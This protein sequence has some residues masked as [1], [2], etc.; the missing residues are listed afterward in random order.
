MV[1]FFSN[2]FDAAP[3][4]PHGHC[5][6]WQKDIVWLNVVANAMIA[7]AYFT[8]PVALFVFVKKRKDIPFNWMFVMFAS[9]IFF[10]GTT[11]V[12]KIVTIWTPIYRID[13]LVDFLTGIISV[14]TGIYLIKIM[15]KAL[16]M[17]SRAQLEAVNNEL[18]ILNKELKEVVV[19]KEEA[20]SRVREERD[21]SL[22]IINNSPNIITAIDTDMKY[23]VFN[24][25][26]ERSTGYKK[27]EVIGRHITEVFPFIKDSEVERCYRETLL[28]KTS[29]LDNFKYKITQTSR[30]GYARGTYSPI[31]GMNGEITGGL[32]ILE[33]ITSQ[34]EMQQALKE[35]E[36]RYRLLAEN[37][38][39]IISVRDKKGV[40]KYVS[41]AIERLLHYKINEVIG[42]SVLEFAHP[43]DIHALKELHD[44]ASTSFDNVIATFRLR[45]KEGKYIWF[46]SISHRIFD[47][48]S[49][50]LH[51]I[52]AA[53]RDIT[54]RKVAEDNL[55]KQT[56][57]LN[58]VL[59]NIKDGIVACDAEG[60]LTLFNKATREFHGMS[61]LP[62]LPDQWPEQYNLF[63]ADG[64]TKMKPDDVPLNKAYKGEE[65]QDQEM[66]ICRT[67]GIKF[68]ILASGRPIYDEHNHKIGAVVVMHNITEQKAAEENLIEK[69]KQLEATN[70]ELEQF[71]YVA[72][73]DLKEPLRM[74]ASYSQLLT[75]SCGDANKDAAEYTSYIVE[76][77]TRMQALLNDLL[78]FSTIDKTEVSFTKVDL[79]EVIKTVEDSLHLKIEE[80]GTEI[81]K[82]QLPAIEAVPSQLYLLFQNLIENA[83][84]FRKEKQSPLINISAEKK[85]HGEW[86]FSIKDNGIGMEEKY[87]EKV[88]VIFQRLHTRDKY[89]GTGIGLAL[90]RK[91]VDFHGGR[92]WF[93]SEPGEGTTFFFTLPERQ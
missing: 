20:E 74:I 4:M 89:P 23:T 73:H 19:N 59:E 78:R 22:S 82:S 49:G 35:S 68:H 64:E 42:R 43:D 2:L 46:E 31:F 34:A 92:I 81:R 21:F 39:D 76:G 67:D 9:F 32:G 91:I 79:N 8:I 1:E 18:D 52:H 90:C 80:T 14:T 88:F 87:A 26:A 77:V 53:S 86:L 33:D 16:T 28:G 66:V 30:E 10:C 13:A 60:K 75:R 48:E 37:S 83:I 63:T 72:S 36:A 25:A 17:P 47:P 29:T 93:E 61:S 65:V 69:N 50:M 41:P 85:K 11:H 7:L 51:E 38:S 62:L 54:E 70:K 71:A 3:F 57:F 56:E 44:V 40:F 55:H 15:P 84:K 6:F 24:P 5:Y 12:L 27:E 58:A 45:N